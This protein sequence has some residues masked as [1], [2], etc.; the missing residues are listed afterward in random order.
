MCAC[1]PISTA[2]RP[3]RPSRCP[4]IENARVLAILGD[5]I[6][7]DH[8]SPA[9]SIAQNSPAAEYLQSYQIQRK[10]WNSYG[11]RRG[12]HEVMMRGTF[13]NIRLK[14]EMAGGKEGG[15][16]KLMPEAR[17]CPSTTPR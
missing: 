2:C 4:D 3:R 12:N 7:T 10:D 14:N 8:I 11:S 17:S 5:S 15:W 6:T 9:G 13:A 1:R 16:T